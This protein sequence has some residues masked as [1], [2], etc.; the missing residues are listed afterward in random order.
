MNPSK[1]PWEKV[2]KR[3][4]DYPIYL[5]ENHNNRMSDRY[6]DAFE[7]MNIYR[8]I[9]HKLLLGKSLNLRRLIVKLEKNTFNLHKI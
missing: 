8:R 6:D 4:S 3:V 5:I 1:K 9:R 7:K 2:I